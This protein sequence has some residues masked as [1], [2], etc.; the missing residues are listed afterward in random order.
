NIAFLNKGVHFLVTNKMTKQIT[1]FYSESGIEDFVKKKAENKLMSNPISC[2]ANDD[3]DD[4]EIS[5]VWTTGREQFHVF[6][7]GLYVPEGGSLIGGVKSAVTSFFKSKI[8]G[9]IDPDILRRGLVCAI[10]CK[11][12]N[13]SF[14]NQTKS[15]INNPNLRILAN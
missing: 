10:N 1:E 6:V 9:E 13:P 7:N 12:A 3:M 8:N 2:H 15:K 4:L 5:F 14:A 11:V